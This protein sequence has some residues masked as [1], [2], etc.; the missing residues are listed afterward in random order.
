MAGDDLL[1][2][3]QQAARRVE[4]LRRRERELAGQYNAPVPAQK[5]PP[6]PAP[7]DPAP[8]SEQWLL[9]ALILLLARNGADAELLAAL[10]YVLL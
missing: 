8:D 4:R 6:A 2:L 3:Q 1:T 5:Q 7:D 10:L 9:T